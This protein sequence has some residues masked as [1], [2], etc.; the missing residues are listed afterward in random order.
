[1]SLALICA[2]WVVAWCATG[3]VLYRIARRQRHVTNKI[4]CLMASIGC[5][6]AALLSSSMAMTMRTYTRLT[7]EQ[8]IARV[9]CTQPTGTPPQYRLHYTPLI[10]HEQPTRIFDMVGDQWM[11]S[12]D[13]LKW[14]P[15][16]NLVGMHTVH[17]PTRISGR[18]LRPK[19]AQTFPH[20]VHE[21]NGGTDTWWLAL[22]QAQHVS[23]LIEAVYGNGVYTFAHP[24][25]TYTI[26][27]STSGY[28]VK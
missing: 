14:H 28:L 6:L 4:A 12:G 3:I 27:V 2:L 16:L 5:V 23:H 15:W 22:Y 7:F 21:L 17:K 25:H 11:V 19:D 18:F 9:Y 10:P 13:I 26:Y 20:T 1:M 24:G 8:P